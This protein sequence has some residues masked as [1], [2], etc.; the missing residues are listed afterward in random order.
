MPTARSPIR[1]EKKRRQAFQTK[2]CLHPQALPEKNAWGKA[3]KGRNLMQ[4]SFQ[5]FHKCMGKGPKG[6]EPH[7]NQLS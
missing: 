6:P 2:D 7:A 1:R 4:T 3:S 5:E